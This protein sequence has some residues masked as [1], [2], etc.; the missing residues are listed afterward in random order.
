MITRLKPH[1][2]G[3][4]KN[5]LKKKDLP[6]RTNLGSMGLLPESM[7]V[8]ISRLVLA[9]PLQVSGFQSLMV[10]ALKG[11]CRAGR[12]RLQHIQDEVSRLRVA[13]VCSLNSVHQVCGWSEAVSCLPNTLRSGGGVCSTNLL[14]TPKEML[15]CGPPCPRLWRWKPAKSAT[16]T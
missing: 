4:G 15:F 6:Q 11:H 9:L 12:G 13:P 2:R 5:K 3:R 1:A 8:P 16:S 10:G 7:G 14:C